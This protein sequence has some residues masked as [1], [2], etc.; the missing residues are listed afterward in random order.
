MK[1]LAVGYNIP[2]FGDL[3]TVI[4]PN[5]NDDSFPDS[6]D[7]DTTSSSSTTSI[8]TTTTTTTTTTSTTT[9][10]TMQ[11]ETATKT[12]TMLDL[13][14]KSGSLSTWYHLKE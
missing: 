12:M 10:T 14:R 5:E 9:T 13:V 11:P 7:W 3:D 4:I 6:Y 8:T 1:F 2:R